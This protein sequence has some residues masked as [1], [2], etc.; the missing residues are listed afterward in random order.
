MPVYESDFSV[1]GHRIYRPGKEQAIT[2]LKEETR[3]D[4]KKVFYHEVLPPQNFH[5][6]YLYVHLLP[7][8]HQY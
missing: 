2:L 3:I 6:L 5:H 4:D 8:R 1:Y 7:H